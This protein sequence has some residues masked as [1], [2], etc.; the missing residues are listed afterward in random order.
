MTTLLRFWLDVILLVTFQYGARPR[1][2]LDGSAER[3][4]RS[5][6]EASRYGKRSGQPVDW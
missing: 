3:F 2:F 6:D 5:P 4:S 1:T